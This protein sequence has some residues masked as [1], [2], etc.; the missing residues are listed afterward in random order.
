[1][2]KIFFTI[3]LVLSI[4]LFLT[5]TKKAD[6]ADA[7]ISVSASP[8]TAK[9]GE[10][11]TFT[12]NVA[13]APTEA[14]YVEM[15]ISDASTPGEFYVK[16][17]YSFQQKINTLTYEWYTSQS[18]VGEHKYY[19]SLEKSNHDVLKSSEVKTFNLSA[20]S[21]DLTSAPVVGNGDE[22]NI[23]DLENNGTV[24]AEFNFGNLGKVIYP[25]TKINSIQDAIVVILT[26]M[27]WLAGVLALIA[28]IYSGAM[29]I[30]AGGDAAKAETGRKNLTWAIIGLVI[31]LLSTVMIN[32]INSVF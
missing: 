23:A 14:Y 20:N 19:A 28:I 12:I 9:V 15:F 16:Q 10:K 7:G 8:S 18:S 30:T 3:F 6:A 26:W 13:N 27:L 22:N 29:Y 25:D 31:V 2:K 21:D 1:M 11:V 5:D 32:Y 24:K 4:F 17:T